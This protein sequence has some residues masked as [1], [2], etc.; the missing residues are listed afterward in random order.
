MESTTSTDIPWDQI[1]VVIT[2]ALR[3]NIHV[4]TYDRWLLFHHCNAVESSVLTTDQ[5]YLEKKLPVY[6]TCMYF[7]SLSLFLKQYGV[8]YF[9]STDPVLGI[10]SNWEMTSSIQGDVCRSYATPFYI[11]NLSIHRY[12]DPWVAGWRTVWTNT[13]VVEEWRLK[14]TVN[15][16]SKS[17]THSRNY[18]TFYI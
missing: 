5:K 6:W 4:P 11:R 14:E 7:F 13:S 10:I 3:T 15:I 16:L 2:I 1:I 17:R 9:H 12:W 8:H 18:N